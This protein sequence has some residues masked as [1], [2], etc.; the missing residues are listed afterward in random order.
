MFTFPV[1]DWKY[2]FKTNFVPK[3]QNYQL[4][5]KFG[6]ETNSNMQNSMEVFTFLFRKENSLSGQIWYKKSKLSV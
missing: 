5:L 2:P 1:F 3:N 6:N 4:K